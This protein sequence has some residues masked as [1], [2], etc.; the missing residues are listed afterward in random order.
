MRLNFAELHDREPHQVRTDFGDHDERRARA[1]RLRDAL[2]RPRPSAQADFDEI[3]RHHRH[4]V[5]ISRR[6]ESECGLNH[7]LFGALHRKYTGA[8]PRCNWPDG[9]R[10]DARRIPVNGQRS[11]G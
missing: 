11:C 3:A 1:Y 4:L 7:Y 5:R 2:G 6:G 8:E 10:V 9:Q